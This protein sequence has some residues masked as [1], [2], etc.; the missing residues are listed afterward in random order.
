MA[1]WYGMECDHGDTWSKFSDTDTE[2]TED[3][4]VCP[5]AGHPAII[6]SR[7]K[8]D[9][10]VKLT[11]AA[12]SRPPESQGHKTSKFFLEM[13]TWD[14]RDFLRSKERYTWEDAVKRAEL[15][16]NLSWE[17]AERR[18]TRLKM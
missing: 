18:W 8:L 9:R 14:G 1:T 3:E 10:L 4:L 16:H 2:P 6:L 12:T 7:F 11:I 13:S 15:F 5:Q 17:D